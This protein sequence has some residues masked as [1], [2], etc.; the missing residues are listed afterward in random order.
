MLEWL[1]VVTGIL[2]VWLAAKQSLYCWP[3]S[4]INLGIYFYIFLTHGL[5][6]DSGLQ[7][8]YLGLTLYGWWYWKRPSDAL[9]VRVSVSVLNLKQRVGVLLLC[10]GITLMIA[11]VLQAATDSTVPWLDA[12]TTAVSLVA[13]ALTARKVLESWLLWIWANI[14]YCGLYVYK[15]L[16][17]TAGLYA[18]FI[19]LAIYG[20]NEWQRSRA[21]PLEKQTS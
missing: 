16:L 14:F 6:A 3:V 20:W 2:Y 5:Y 18:F 1:G 4:L 8:F 19:V 7:V 12:H 15:D 21:V 11:M 13:Q 9:G 10:A 17:P